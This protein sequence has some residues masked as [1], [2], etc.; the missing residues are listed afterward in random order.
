MM[1]FAKS[2][3]AGAPVCV[4]TTG[5]TGEG[6]GEIFVPVEN[7]L[8]L[9]EAIMEEGARLDCRPIGLGARDTL[10]LEK[11]FCL[12]GNELDERTTPFEA[13]L[14]WVLRMEK[15]DFVGREA[16]LRQKEEGVH[17]ELR[18][19]KMEERGIPRHGYAVRTARGEGSVTSG[20]MSPMLGLGIALAYIPPGAEEGESVEIEIHGK[21]RQGVIISLPFV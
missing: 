21:W 17:R 11:G 10:R 2:I 12:Y 5:Y 13:G 15:G 9:W 1:R 3:F 8:R 6:G 4:A 14:G 19:V 20:T 7:A 16:L 18:A